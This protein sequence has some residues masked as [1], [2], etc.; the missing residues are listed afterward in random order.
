MQPLIPRGTRKRIVGSPQGGYL[1]AAVFATA[2]CAGLWWT[3]PRLATPHVRSLSPIWLA[4][5]ASRINACP[6]RRI[7]RGGGGDCGGDHRGLHRAVD[8]APL[9]HLVRCRNDS[10]RLR[11]CSGM[12]PDVGRSIVCWRESY[13]CILRRTRRWLCGEPGAGRLVVVALAKR[14]AT[15]VAS[16]GLGDGRRRVDRPS[17]P[18]VVDAGFQIWADRMD[19]V[20][21]RDDCGERNYVAVDLYR[22]ASH[23]KTPRA[24]A[25]TR[26]HRCAAPVFRNDA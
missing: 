25:I 6:Y 7:S 9:R 26:V 4:W 23:R 14:A 10:G 22:G 8:V 16:A 13:G 19:W 20:P 21:D 17:R 12:T 2:L 1:A 18:G 5:N 15:P 24:T 3:A 11:Q